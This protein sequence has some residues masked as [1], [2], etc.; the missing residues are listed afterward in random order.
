MTDNGNIKPTHMDEL[1]NHESQQPRFS[2]EDLNPDTRYE[3]SI[4]DIL[5]SPRTIEA[6][7]RQGVNAA[8]LDPIGEEQVRKLIG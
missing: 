2:I 5:N 8:D 4:R 1:V 6:L 3:A 7:R